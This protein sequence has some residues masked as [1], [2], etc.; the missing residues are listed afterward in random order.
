MFGICCRCRTSQ[1]LHHEHPW[2]EQH[3]RYLGR[4]FAPEC[5]PQAEHVPGSLVAE[6]VGYHNELSEV[7][8]IAM[9][10]PGSNLGARVELEGRVEQGVGP[11][12]GNE[13]P[14]ARFSP[15]TCRASF[16]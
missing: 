2:P 7:S 8:K 13:V 5:A 6:V 15:Q 4:G 11:W 3:E 12:T 9:P 1:G 14:G 16:E 10:E